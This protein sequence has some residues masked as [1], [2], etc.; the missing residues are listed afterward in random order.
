MKQLWLLVMLMVVCRGVSVADE[1]ISGERPHFPSRGGPA[2]GPSAQS[3]Q[4]FVG[5][6]SNAG[7][8]KEPAAP[9]AASAQRERPR[10][11]K[12]PLSMSLQEFV[13]WEKNKPPKGRQPPPAAV[14][15]EAPASD[16]APAE[17]KEPAA[18]VATPA[19]VDSSA[20]DDEPVAP[21]EVAA[22]DGRQ[23]EI[24]ATAAVEAA[25]PAFDDKHQE[26][27]SP[28]IVL[29]PP[30][31]SALGEPV[32]PETLEEKVEETVYQP[33]DS[34]QPQGVD[35]PEDGAEPE[36]IAAIPDEATADTDILARLGGKAAG[37]GLP[38]FSLLPGRSLQPPDPIEKLDVFSAVRRAVDTH[39]TITRSL[40]RL[41]EQNEQLGVARAGYYPQVSSGVSSGYRSTTGRSE[42]AFNVSASQMLYDF[43]KVS[44]SVAAARHGIDRDQ[45]R[46]LNEV[47]TLARDTVHTFIEVQ[48]YQSLQDIAREQ[49]QSIIEI[50]ELVAKRSAK[51]A[52]SRSDEIQAR[53]RKESAMATEQQLKAQH[54]AWKRALQN[55]V[56]ID[57][58][59][60][61]SKGYPRDFDNAC[62]R[63]P[64]NF[65]NAP[66]ILIAEA[67]RAEAMASIERA[68]AEFL[69]TVSLRANYDHY[70]NRQTNTMAFLE[71]DEDFSVTFNLASNIFQGGAIRARK[72][73]ADFALHAATAARDVAYLTLSRGFLEAR[74]QT[75]SLANRFTLLEAQYDS[76]VK[77][78]ELY[79]QQY[80][81][82][83]TRTLLDILNTEQEI[84]QARFEKENTLF[85]LRR[86]QI[87]CLYS[88]AAIRPAFSLADRVVQGM[89]IE[90]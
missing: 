24:T 28:P 81:S 54:D 21:A 89:S 31:E 19:V 47:D 72:R 79:R 77:T 57:G 33:D 78:Q 27:S 39:P 40:G 16:E 36:E 1:G 59:L 18:A 13:E 2:E 76:L 49:I 4:E 37:A 83:G 14:S 87:D 56:G 66:Q 85:D 42:E 86:L 26:R 68:K 5:Q 35:Q 8:N 32:A 64:E 41:Y 51:G 38:F 29:V 84:R 73:A 70:F 90:P 74:D 80:L 30:E 10:H 62:L 9:V 46:V 25:E 12:A 44:S 63:L 60:R 45:A 55:L 48:R 3:L 82:L 61:M 6:D 71:D 75:A 34:G 67:E 69:P 50:E 23:R 22:E 17:E 58:E 53:S 15:A 20:S 7:D 88:V 11:G 65:D 43:G 52:S